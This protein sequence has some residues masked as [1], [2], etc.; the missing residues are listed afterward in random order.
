MNEIFDFHLTFWDKITLPFHR[1]KNFINHRLYNFKN[2]SQRFIRGFAQT[3]VW[4][5]DMWFINTIKSMLKNFL[6]THKSNPVDISCE[7]WKSIICEMIK[8]LDNMDESEVRKSLNI[9]GNNLSIESF[10]EIQKVMNINKD[11]FFDLFKE[12]FWNLWD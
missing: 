2:R 6:D 5:M 1:I 8:C 3:D 4:N 9:E 7:E 11:R 10:K 12:H